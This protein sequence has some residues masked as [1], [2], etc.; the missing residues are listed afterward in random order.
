MEESLS[1]EHSGELFGDSLEHLLDGGG[2]TNEGDRHLETLGRDITDSGLD[3]A[4]ARTDRLA[5]LRN[6]W[7]LIE[8]VEQ[9]ERG[10]SI[11][12]GVIHLL[13]WISNQ[14]FTAPEGAALAPA[15]DIPVAL[16]TIHG[17]KG[18]EFPIV[19][20]PG[21]ARRSLQDQDFT[22]V[23]LPGEEGEDRGLIIE[24]KTTMDHC[25]T[26]IIIP[27]M[28]YWAKKINLIFN[29]SLLNIS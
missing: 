28:H 12:N 26:P 29:H 21:L 8:M 3:V 5:S 18:L 7:R 24:I 15:A 4:Y 2:V 16:T 14:R 27:L 17:S 11:S 25:R 22:E 23:E 9:V 20:L 19:I 13:S 1:S 6:I 10:A